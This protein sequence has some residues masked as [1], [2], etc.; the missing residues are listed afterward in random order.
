MSRNAKRDRYALTVR[1]LA[2]EG[3]SSYAVSFAYISSENRA[4]PA[5]E[6]NRSRA[7]KTDTFLTGDESSVTGDN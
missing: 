5:Q 2:Q 3:N 6:D 1:T 4:F 7:E